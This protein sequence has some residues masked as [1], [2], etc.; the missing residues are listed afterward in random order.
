MPRSGV[1]TQVLS[2]YRSIL[3][4]ARR[5]EDAGSREGVAAFAREEFDK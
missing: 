3:R 1:A 5:L 4:A 2:L